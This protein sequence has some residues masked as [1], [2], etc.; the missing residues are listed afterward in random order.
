MTL[1]IV[2]GVIVVATLVGWRVLL[3]RKRKQEIE[4]YRS[5]A[6]VAPSMPPV[7]PTEEAVQ[8]N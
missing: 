7:A 5:I 4:A 6:P 8:R 1:Y 2:L 3:D